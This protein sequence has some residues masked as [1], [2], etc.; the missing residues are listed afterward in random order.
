MNK[1]IALFWTMATGP[2]EPPTRAPHPGRARPAEGG[3]LHVDGGG[4]DEQQRVSVPDV[5][6]EGLRGQV[7]GEPALLSGPQESRPHQELELEARG[8]CSKGPQVS[9]QVI[10]V[11]Y[12]LHTS[13]RSLLWS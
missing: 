3:H 13:R 9:P 8:A 4:S 7:A 2:A 10:R 11:I 5:H 12:H 1:E 6:L